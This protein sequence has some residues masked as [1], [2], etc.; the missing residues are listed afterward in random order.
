MMSQWDVLVNG[1]KQDKV[2]WICPQ[3]ECVFGGTTAI[4][5]REVEKIFKAS[6]D[7]L[8]GFPKNLA[9]HVIVLGTP[10]E[11]VRPAMHGKQGN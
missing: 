7:H 11:F 3:V 8:V 4:V 9:T 5:A 6:A 10:S 1:E 2:C